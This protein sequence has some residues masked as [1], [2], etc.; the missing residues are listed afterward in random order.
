MWIVEY[1]NCRLCH[2]WMFV[3]VVLVVAIQKLYMEMHNKCQ[4]KEIKSKE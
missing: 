3:V 4:N 2:L 1:V